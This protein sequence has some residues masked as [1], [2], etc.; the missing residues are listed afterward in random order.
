MAEQE[1]IKALEEIRSRKVWEESLV[2]QIVELNDA[3]QKTQK[4]FDTYRE[5]TEKYYVPIPNIVPFLEIP[6]CLNPLD[7]VKFA[8]EK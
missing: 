8:G 5:Y 6:K 4:N 1:W 7:A 2:K 3:I